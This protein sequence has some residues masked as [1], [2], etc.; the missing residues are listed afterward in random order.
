M[1]GVGLAFAAWVALGVA[2]CSEPSVAVDAGA[3][4]APDAAPPMPPAPDIP[5]LA[6]GVPPWRP[7]R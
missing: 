5:W 1:R 3:D 4:A 6:D 7:R 2:G